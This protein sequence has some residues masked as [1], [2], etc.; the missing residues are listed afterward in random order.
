MTTFPQ[1]KAKNPGYTTLKVFGRQ[2]RDEPHHLVYRVMLYP[3]KGKLDAEALKDWC[4]VRY[5]DDNRA[6]AR[7][8]FRIETYLHK[9]GKRFV[10]RVLF[11]R[12]SDD[13]LIELKLRFGT[14]FSRDKV[15]RDGR[16]R[17]PRLSAEELD[18]RNEWLD[19]FY[20]DIAL[21]RQ[22][23]RDEAEARVPA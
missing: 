8:R 13:E 16:I 9:S 3:K 4:A 5:L 2:H 6:V 1:K 22:K 11:E 17:K 19:R 18:V 23:A 15:I 14:A 21:R 20:M 12:I 10:N 7:S